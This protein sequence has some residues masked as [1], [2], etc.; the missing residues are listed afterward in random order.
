LNEDGGRSGKTSKVFRIAWLRIP[1]DEMGFRAN[2]L[3]ILNDFP[4]IPQDKLQIPQDKLGILNDS[5][6]IPQDKLRIPQDK[7]RIVRD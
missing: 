3:G 2:Q 4:G 1:A 7:L 6:G 5:I